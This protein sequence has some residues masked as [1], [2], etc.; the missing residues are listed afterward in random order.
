[1]LFGIWIEYITIYEKN[2]R[3]IYLYKGVKL[4]K[5][6]EDRTIVLIEWKNF[7]IIKYFC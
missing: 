1:M 6:E 2:N 7:I 3:K 5:E 4:T